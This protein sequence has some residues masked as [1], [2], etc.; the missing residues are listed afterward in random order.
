M[1]TT[2]IKLQ[3]KNYDLFFASTVSSVFDLL[4]AAVALEGSSADIYKSL[5]WIFTFIESELNL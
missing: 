3:A 1:T 2:E 4:S 5:V